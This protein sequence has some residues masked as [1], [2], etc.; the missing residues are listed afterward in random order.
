MYAIYSKKRNQ[1]ESLP[2]A[3]NEQVDNINKARKYRN[4]DIAIQDFTDCITRYPDFYWSLRHIET[5]EV[6]MTNGV[7][8]LSYWKSKK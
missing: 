6:I 1:R 7:Q 5:G 2:T 3:Y 4:I 8:V